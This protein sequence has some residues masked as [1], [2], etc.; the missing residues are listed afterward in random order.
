MVLVH[1]LLWMFGKIWPDHIESIISV[2]IPYPETV[3]ELH[4]FVT[5][6]KSDAVV[7]LADVYSTDQ[8][9]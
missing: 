2:E 9:D 1:I 6:N 8:L 7:G 5:T 4:S 3:A